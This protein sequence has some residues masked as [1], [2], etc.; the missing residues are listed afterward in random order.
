M[1]D[2]DIFAFRP[3]PDGAAPAGRAAR[4]RVW[5]WVLG[6]V[7]LLLALLVAG[8]LAAVSSISDW[9]HHSGHV[10][11]NGEP[12][13]GWGFRN[14]LDIDAGD[15]L[16]A[17]LGL[18]IALLAVVVIVPLAV[19]FSL[20]LAGLGIAIGLA[21]TAGAIGLVVLLVFSPLWLIGLLVWLMLRRRPAA[22]ASAAR[23]AA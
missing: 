12:W 6:G 18:G 21:A 4:R 1:N 3:V 16:W 5:P 14:G 9:V 2:E 8:G 15:G 22:R 13:D 11:I 17:L 10:V 23:M 19:V 20:L 7:L